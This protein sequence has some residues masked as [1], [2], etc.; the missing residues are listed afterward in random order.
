MKREATVWKYVNHPN[1]L[2]F[3]GYR[4]VRGTPWLVTP[5]CQY[6]NLGSYIAGN[7]GLTDLR[8]LQLA[9]N[10]VST[11]M[12]GTEVT[13]QR[14]LLYHSSAVQPAVWRTSTHAI[15]L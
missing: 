13:D 2:R 10:P 6:G 4:V 8:R 9:S 11:H 7:P 3:I 5:W 1:I 15:R 14:V 12:Y